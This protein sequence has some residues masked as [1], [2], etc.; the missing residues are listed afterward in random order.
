MNNSRTWMNRA[1]EILHPKMA[2]ARAVSVLAMVG[3]F[4][5]VVAITIGHAQT[6]DKPGPTSQPPRTVDLTQPL[7]VSWR[8]E[9]NQTL[10]LTPAVAAERVY[11]PLAGG[12]IVSLMGAHGQLNWR[13]EMGG[14]LSASPVADQTAIFVA[15]ETVQSDAT[16]HRATGILR[17]LGREGGVTQWM[18]ALPMPL[19]GGLALSNG[20]IFGGGVDGKLYALESKTGDT[21]WFFDYSAPFNSQ[22]V[23]SA[24]RV[25]VG[26]EDGSLLALDEA[27]GKLLWRFRTRGAV[28]GPVAVGNDVVY[29]G[30]R[31][32]YV[33]AVNVTDGRL[34]WRKR[35]GAG[36][37]AVAR[38]GEELLV[39]SLD[40][41]VY[42]FSFAGARV[43]KRRLPGRIAS[44][45]LVTADAALFMPFSSSSGVVLE[46]R[47][48]RQ[49][50]LLPAG[51]EIAISASPIAV[52]EVV[53]LTTEHGLLA[54]TQ[55]SEK[56]IIKAIE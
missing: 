55:P 26:S 21:L 10:N 38:S 15:S 52:G 11:L 34:V 24:T 9:S 51:E 33:Y 44:Q 39:A 2:V 54:F 27:T 8:Y 32:G 53:L 1:V 12:T 41:F 14:E 50:N 29:F 42:K 6:A 46:L 47:G 45:P 22:P 20:K 28:R 40:N 17:A 23:V 5:V 3:I 49:V 31:D 16:N 19:R 7:T 48:G 30:S 13:A 4:A 37:E 43:W 25:F 35:T 56:P 36:V 18:R